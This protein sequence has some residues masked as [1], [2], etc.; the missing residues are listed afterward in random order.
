[1]W[2]HRVGHKNWGI[3][4]KDPTKTGLE[5]SQI[6]TKFCTSM[7]SIWAPERPVLPSA[8][9]AAFL[10]V[11]CA[12]CPPYSLQNTVC[13]Q[14][15][16]Y[17]VLWLSRKRCFYKALCLQPAPKQTPAL[18]VAA[19]DV[20]G[21]S[22]ESFGWLGTNWLKWWSAPILSHFGNPMSER[23]IWCWRG[24]AFRAP[25]LFLLLSLPLTLKE[26]STSVIFTGV[27]L[28]RNQCVWATRYGLGTPLQVSSSQRNFELCINSTLLDIMDIAC[29]AY[30][31]FLLPE[32]F[33][34]SSCGNTWEDMY[35][36][37]Q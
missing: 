25:F 6:N 3:A 28:Q 37:W 15:L 2:W 7:S 24:I 13:F 11:S 35:Y 1:M 12:W 34:I 18:P 29:T 27:V 21:H 20:E 5:P 31:H 10:L 9:H 36:T 30:I 16:Q 33:F 14:P 22:V 19:V 23:Q 17:P 26:M 32:W 4:R 8:A